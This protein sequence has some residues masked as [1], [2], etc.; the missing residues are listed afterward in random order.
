M[1]KRLALL[2]QRSTSGHFYPRGALLATSTPPGKGGRH[3]YPPGRGGRARVDVLGVTPLLG[4]NI[5]AEENL[6]RFIDA[7]VL[8]P[9]PPVVDELPA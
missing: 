3:F 9:T 7:R 8:P 6:V 1:N 5:R 2:P 4:C